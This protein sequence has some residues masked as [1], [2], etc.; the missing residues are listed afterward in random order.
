M[1]DDLDNEDDDD[2]RD[3]DDG[4]DPAERC[5]DNGCEDDGLGRCMIC[6]RPLPDAPHWPGIRLRLPGRLKLARTRARA[7]ERRALMRGRREILRMVPMLRRRGFLVPRAVDL[8]RIVDARVVCGRSASASAVVGAF[9]FWLGF[10]G[11]RAPTW[12]GCLH[13]DGDGCAVDRR[14]CDHGF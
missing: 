13:C 2:D 9:G 4:Q 10:P 1:N 6:D 8:V 7:K 11:G 14:D 12:R 3:L 5:L